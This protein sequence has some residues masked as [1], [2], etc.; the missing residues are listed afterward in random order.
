[1]S[2]PVLFRHV[3]AMSSSAGSPCGNLRGLILIKCFTTFSFAF[4]EGMFLWT[5]GVCAF[6]N[7]SIFITSFSQYGRLF[8]LLILVTIC[9]LWG[10]SGSPPYFSWSAGEGW[11]TVSGILDLVNLWRIQSVQTRDSTPS[12]TV[13]SLPGGLWTIERKIP[14][15]SV[16]T[17][18][19][20]GREQEAKQRKER[21]AL[22]SNPAVTVRAKC[23]SLVPD[24][25]LPREDHKRRAQARWCHVITSRNHSPADPPNSRWVWG[26]E[27]FPASWQNPGWGSIRRAQLQSLC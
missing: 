23:D 12:V 24:E 14:A 16:V 7:P 11:N 3:W 6:C 13:C 19:C 1:M 15:M 10:C 9:S 5:W 26:E 17:V 21:Q 4:T 27:E 2:S 18:L 25:S 8:V 22:H 20:R